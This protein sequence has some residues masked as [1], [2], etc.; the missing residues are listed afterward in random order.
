M[1]DIIAKS[2]VLC[3]LCAVIIRLASPLQRNL[4]V[5][6][7]KIVTV[8]LRARSIHLRNDESDTFT[9]ANRGS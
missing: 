9:F 6:I 3:V 2:L 4:K 7:E 5:A 1:K 8:C